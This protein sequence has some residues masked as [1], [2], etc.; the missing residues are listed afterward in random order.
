VEVVR[1]SDVVMQYR[2]GQQV[3]WPARG[4][5]VCLD[6]QLADSH[7]NI[8]VHRDRFAGSAVPCQIDAWYQLNGTNST[9]HLLEGTRHS[10]SL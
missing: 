9:G 1:R 3:T 2:V 10:R 5:A 8:L 4:D 6:D 7:Y